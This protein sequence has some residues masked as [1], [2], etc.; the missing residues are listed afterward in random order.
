METAVDMDKLFKEYE[1][2]SYSNCSPN[3]SYKFGKNGGE[4]MVV[5][6]CQ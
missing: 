3:P 5:A 6:M 1:Y 2:I 4:S